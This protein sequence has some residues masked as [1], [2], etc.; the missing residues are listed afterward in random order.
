MPDPVVPL[1]IEEFY[2]HIDTVADRPVHGHQLRP[3]NRQ[4]PEVQLTRPLAAFPERMFFYVGL[5]YGFC[6]LDG[7]ITERFREAS[8]RP[9][10]TQLHLTERPIVTVRGFPDFSKAR[11]ARLLQSC[12]MGDH[13]DLFDYIASQVIVDR[14][15]SRVWKIAM[16]TCLVPDPYAGAQVV[17]GHN[18]VIFYPQTY[19]FE[20][21]PLPSTG[22]LLHAPEVQHFERDDPA[23]KQDT[24]KYLSRK[25]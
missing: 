1:T 13:T 6:R 14:A 9:L 12:P 4:D 5:L 20:Y 17:T 22:L 15:R 16:T 10:L 8:G 3:E 21:K 24:D 23:F 19:S 7:S 2:R 25:E 18:L 11:V